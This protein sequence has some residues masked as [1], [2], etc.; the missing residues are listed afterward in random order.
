MHE[1]DAHWLLLEHS[2]ALLPPQVLL[3]SL[4]SPDTHTA[5]ASV[6]VPPCA[7]SLGIGEPAARSSTQRNCDWSQWLAAWQ[8]ESSQQPAGPEATQWPLLHEFDTH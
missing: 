1:F 7:P 5:A 6:Q 2:A 3:V 4:H 8:F